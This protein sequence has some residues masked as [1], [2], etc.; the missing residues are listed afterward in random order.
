MIKVKIHSAVVKDV[1][2]M[3]GLRKSE[4]GLFFT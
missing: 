2:L 4:R 1:V 3:S